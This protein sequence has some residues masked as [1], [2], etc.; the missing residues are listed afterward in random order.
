MQLKTATGRTN[1]SSA[2]ACRTATTAT[3]IPKGLTC[4][5][6]WNTVVRTMDKQNVKSSQGKLCKPDAQFIL[7]DRDKHP[8]N[9]MEVL[10]SC[11]QDNHLSLPV[12]RI[13]R[14]RRNHCDEISRFFRVLCWPSFN[15]SIIMSKSQHRLHRPVPA[16]VLPAVFQN[17]HQL[18]VRHM[19][20]HHPQRIQMSELVKTF[21]VNQATIEHGIGFCHDDPPEADDASLVDWKQGSLYLGRAIVPRHF[22]LNQ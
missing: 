15:R 19:L 18:L 14:F 13:S 20:D 6:S 1:P 2:H 8:V 22:T 10:P 4:V 11:T 9:W 7:F 3:V 16:T 21:F 17:L 5:L 12:Q